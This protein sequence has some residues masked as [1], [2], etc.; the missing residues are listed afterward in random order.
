VITVVTKNCDPLLYTVSQLPIVTSL[1]RSEDGN[2][3]VWSGIGHGQEEWAV[4]LQSEVLIGKFLPINGAT[5]SAL[6]G[7]LSVVANSSISDS[8]FIE[9]YIVAGEV[10]ALK[11]EVGN[12]A[13][14]G[15]VL[16]MLS[17]SCAPADFG[18]VLGRPRDHII[19]E[20]EVDASMAV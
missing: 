18:K 14:E 20:D 3:R 6:S 16:V 7:Y 2:L 13:V 11:H 5:A 19:E 9:T 8:I 17:I 12:N 4:V 10:A 1:Q 15:A